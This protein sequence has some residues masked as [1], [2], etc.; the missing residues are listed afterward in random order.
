[1]PLR[2]RRRSLI[3]VTSFD[4]FYCMSIDSHQVLLQNEKYDPGVYL[5]SMSPIVHQKSHPEFAG[6]LNLEGAVD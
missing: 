5:F 6:T 4:E 3:A 1:M 2:L